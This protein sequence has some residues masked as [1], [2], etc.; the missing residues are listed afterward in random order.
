MR[1]AHLIM[2]PR[3]A[4]SRRLLARVTFSAGRLTAFG[5]GLG[6]QKPGREPKSVTGWKRSETRLIFDF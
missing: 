5:A 6:R 3:W 2:R 4:R 1:V